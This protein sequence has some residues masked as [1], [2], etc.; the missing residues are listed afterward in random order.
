MEIRRDSALDH[1]AHAASDAGAGDAGAMATDKLPSD[2][3][4]R[5][6]SPWPGGAGAAAAAG[7]A[8]AAAVTLATNSPFWQECGGGQ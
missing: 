6:V 4:S 2:L 7:V 1:I 5:G 8:A 3:D